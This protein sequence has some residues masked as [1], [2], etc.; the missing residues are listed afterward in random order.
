MLLYQ[1]TRLRGVAYAFAM[2]LCCIPAFQELAGLLYGILF[3]SIDARHC[4]IRL[5]GQQR[6]HGMS[7]LMEYR[8]HL[9]AQSH[10]NDCK[11][12]NKPNPTLMRGH[13]VIENRGMAAT[14]RKGDW[15]FRGPTP[16]S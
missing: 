8:D 11:N 7:R 10:T 13:K 1:G 14:L 4:D 6:L 2:W 5:G 16:W 12:S 9:T 3:N 15:Q